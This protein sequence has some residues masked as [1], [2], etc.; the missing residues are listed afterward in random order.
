MNKRN[1]QKY[2]PV[3]DFKG[4]LKTKYSN[5]ASED[6]YNWKTF[7][8]YISKTPFA[9]R[10]LHTFQEGVCPICSQFLEFRD[11]VIH[12]INYDQFCSFKRKEIKNLKN[13]KA[14]VIANCK[15]CRTPQPCFEKIV[16]IHKNCHFIL[17]KME[18]RVKT[19]NSKNYDA[20]FWR[21][22]T[23]DELF[24][25]MSRIKTDVG[26][27]L[28]RQM[29]FDYKKNI[30]S[31]IPSRG[32]YFCPSRKGFYVVFDIHAV[33]MWIGRFSKIGIS[34]REFRYKLRLDFNQEQYNRYH[35]YFIKMFLGII[36]K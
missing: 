28:D 29:N 24:E 19:P 18:G 25:L 4:L 16:L 2:Y 14:K 23:G 9:K 8:H 27:A 20:K 1:Y 12:H 17:H 36:L 30:I 15:S 32:T 3:N 22:K 5:L 6:L 7:V 26:L 35:E 33:D 11:S 10:Y 31:L 13:D 21:S 34:A